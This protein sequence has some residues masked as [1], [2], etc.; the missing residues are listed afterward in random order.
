M[1]RLGI[2]LSLSLTLVANLIV[3]ELQAQWTTAS[4]SQDRRDLAATSVG[5]KIFFA[6]GT[7]YSTHGNLNIVDNTTPA[8]IR[9][10]QQT[11][12]KRGLV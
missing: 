5:T 2:I 9:G 3:I 4:L 6:G 8:L 7:S 10:R 1:K 11:Y 12:L